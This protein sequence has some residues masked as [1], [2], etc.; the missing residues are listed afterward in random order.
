MLLAHGS[1]LWVGPDCD[2]LLNAGDS[3][4]L[5][6]GTVGWAGTRC[7]ICCLVRR[8]KCRV[9]CDQSCHEAALRVAAP[10][11]ALHGRDVGQPLRHE[12]CSVACLPAANAL[13]SSGPPKHAHTPR[14][15]A[16]LAPPPRSLAA[17]AA[18]SRGPCRAGACTGR[19][20][21]SHH[22]GRRHLGGGWAAGDGNGS[23][24]RGALCCS[25]GWGC[26]RHLCCCCCCDGCAAP[27]AGPG[28]GRV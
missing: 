6:A 9:A 3:E 17:A 5:L 12:P 1:G 7:A 8:S 28:C 26:G 14:C 20:L 2:G 11:S 15:S 10:K 19:D 22:L 13:V 16:P 4:T 23:Q 21:S 25:R 27:A 24:R 18:A